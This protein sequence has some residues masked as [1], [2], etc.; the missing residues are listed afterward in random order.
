MMLFKSEVQLKRYCMWDV[1]VVFLNKNY[2]V[3]FR[4]PVPRNVHENLSVYYV[5]QEIHGKSQ[6]T[7]CRD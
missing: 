5:Y 4:D 3:S 6:L 7:K 1:E 2:F